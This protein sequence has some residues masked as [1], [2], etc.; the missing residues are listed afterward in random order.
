M[1]FQ[2]NQID[3]WLCSEDSDSDY[4]LL[5]EVVSDVETVPLVDNVDLNAS[6]FDRQGRPNPLVWIDHSDAQANNKPKP[7]I[8]T[9]SPGM[10]V[11][12]ENNKDPYELFKLFVG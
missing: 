11:N 1:D 3:E 4:N 10:N 5:D 12:V 6:A 2:E 9:G 7:F 8:F